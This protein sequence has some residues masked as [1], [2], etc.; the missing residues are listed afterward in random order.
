MESKLTKWLNHEFSSSGET[1]KDYLTFQRAA[2]R[3]LSSMATEAGC[4]IYK[5]NPNHYEFS[6]VL[7]KKGANAFIYVS[8][9]DVRFFRNEWWTNVLYR[10]M[11]DEKDYTGGS[12]HYCAWEKLPGSISSLVYESES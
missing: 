2:K 11:K 3:E 1:G 8:I 10:T 9:S 7:K 6:C 4:E 5:F 12:N